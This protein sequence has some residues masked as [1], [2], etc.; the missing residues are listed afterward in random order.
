MVAG[1]SGLVVAV[2]FGLALSLGLFALD[3]V[4]R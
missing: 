1:V 3:L 2:G 4:V